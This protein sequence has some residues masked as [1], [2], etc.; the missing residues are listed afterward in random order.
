MQP[1]LQLGDQSLTPS[2]LIILLKRYQLLPQLHRELILDRAIA[3]VQCTPEE[4]FM[5]CQQFK[6]NYQLTSPEAQQAFCDRL[7]QAY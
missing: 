6:A 4:T 7:C 2:D 5:A 1:I 3:N